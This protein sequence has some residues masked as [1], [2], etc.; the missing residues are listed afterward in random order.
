MMARPSSPAELEPQVSEG[1]TLAKSL[2]VAGILG[3]F[4]HTAAASCEGPQPWRAPGAVAYS[5]SDLRIFYDLARESSSAYSSGDLLKAKKL[6]QRY[7]IAA[8]RF[9]CDWNHGN[10]VHNAN[11]ILG[12]IALQEG[13]HAVSVQ[14]LLAA[15]RSRGSPQL[16]TFGPSLL[17]AKRLAEAGEFD[18]VAAYILSIRRFWEAKDLTVL[19]LIGFPDPQ[20]MSTWLET[21][22]SGRSPNFGFNA[23]K[24]P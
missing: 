13:Q 5:E 2:L 3:C 4:L 17:L 11:A 20:P 7:L 18:V 23:D 10:A 22:A 6:S 24:L 16:N 8:E 21:L 12:L 15:G 19:G 9:P 1:E 14:H